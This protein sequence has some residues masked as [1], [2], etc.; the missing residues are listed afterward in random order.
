MLIDADRHIIS[1]NLSVDEEKKLQII[2][3]D[4]KKIIHQTR[5]EDF[6]RTLYSFSNTSN[7]KKQRHVNTNK[8]HTRIILYSAKIQVYTPQPKSIRNS[9][10]RFKGRAGRIPNINAQITAK[11]TD[12]FRRQ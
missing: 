9:A 7:K 8:I 3:G 5:F 12:A 4:R 11:P 2:N 10:D 1:Q 6:N